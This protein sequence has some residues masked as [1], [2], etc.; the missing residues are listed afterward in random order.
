MG[1]PPRRSSQCPSGR[2]DS[3]VVGHI[4]DKASQS[5]HLI[6]EARVRC[7]RPPAWRSTRGRSATMTTQAYHESFAGTGEVVRLAAR[8]ATALHPKTVTV[9]LD[10]SASGQRRTG[11]AAALARRWYAH[12]VGVHVM[13]GRTKLQSSHCYAVGHKAIDQVIGLARRL[14]SDADIDA[15]SAGEEFTALCRQMEVD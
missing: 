15:A 2:N 1:D 6:C 10:G 12:L 5:P 3:F 11:Q 8:S 13:P 7:A 9:F 14:R 4:E